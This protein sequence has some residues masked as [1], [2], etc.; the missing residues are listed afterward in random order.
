MGER[1]T[2]PELLDWLA[3]EFVAEELEHQ[4]DPSADHELGNVS[5]GIDDIAANLDI[6]R[7]NRYLLAHAAAASGR[8]GSAIP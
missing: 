3:T 7:E 8:R 4:S 5:D 6:D 1:P 2:H